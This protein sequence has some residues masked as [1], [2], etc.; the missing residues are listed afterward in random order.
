[1]A[2]ERGSLPTRNHRFG[3]FAG[4]EGLSSQKMIELQ[5]K[6][7]GSMVHGCMPGCIVKCSN[8]FHDNEK[9][10]LTSGLEYESLAM[11]GANLEI[12]DIDVVAAMERK[13]DDYGIDTIDI[14]AALGVLG[15]SDLF[16]F[17]NKTMALDLIDQIGRGSTLGMI[18][19]QGV[20]TT[21]RVLGIDRIPAVKGQAIPAHCSRTMKGLGVTYATSPQGADHTAGFVGEENLSA[22]GQA[23]RS[24]NAQINML[25]LD[26]LGLCYFSFLIGTFLIYSKLIKSLYGIDCSE[27]ELIDMAKV[28]LREEKGFNLGAGIT[29]AADRLPEFLENEPLAPANEVF[30]VPKDDLKAVFGQL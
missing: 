24:R 28:A 13:C 22:E 26:S 14:G 29:E 2:N 30:D 10:Y 8:I 20:S 1:M 19:G 9:R 5:E 12:D 3:S 18:L 11:L 7:G 27:E 17:G 23:E 16:E 15:E 6:R 25:F 21:C 4:S